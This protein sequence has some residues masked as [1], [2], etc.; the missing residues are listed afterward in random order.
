LLVDSV[1]CNIGPRRSITALAAA[2]A[3]AVLWPPPPTCA[4]KTAPSLGLRGCLGSPM[5]VANVGGRARHVPC[6][7]RKITTTAGRTGVNVTH[8]PAHLI[9]RGR[10]HEVDVMGAVWDDHS[11]QG[12][13][14]VLH[15]AA[16]V[17]WVEQPAYT[18]ARPPQ[19][20]TT[21][22]AQRGRAG[23]LL[24]QRGIVRNR[25]GAR[26]R[27]TQ[28]RGR[29]MR[30]RA[31]WCKLMEKAIPPLNTYPLL[32]TMLDVARMS[33]PTRRSVRVYWHCVRIP[34][35]ACHAA[36]T[37]TRNRKTRAEKKTP[38]NNNNHSRGR[39]VQAQSSPLRPRADAPYA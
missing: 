19:P 6:D 32:N 2:A 10:E 5:V 34:M 7:E 24:V 29:R 4:C 20:T 38:S 21:R 35:R 33:L 12:V 8:I 26:A 17:P 22:L 36:S 16:A 1:S 13:G 27:A 25:A 3:A 31:R 15:N 28:S 14:E 30:M 18:D 37:R 23:S 9:Y 39:T 11:D